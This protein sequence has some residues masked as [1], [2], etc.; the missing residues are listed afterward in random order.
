MTVDLRYHTLLSP[1]IISQHAT[2]RLN[3]TVE[4]YACPEEN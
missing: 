3:V 4:G 1:F 2:N